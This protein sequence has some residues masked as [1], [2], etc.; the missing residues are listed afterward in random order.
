MTKYGSRGGH[1]FQCPG[2]K[3]II[4]ETSEDRKVKDAMIK[5]L[6]LNGD[7]VVDCTPGNCGENADLKYGTDKANANKVD[8]FLP[9]HFNSAANNTSIMGCE[10][11]LNPDNKS[12]VAMGNRIL[13]KLSGLGFKNR[14][15]KD[16]VNEEH[17]HDIKQSDMPAVLIEVCFVGASGD[18]ALYKKLGPDIIGKAIAEGVVGHSIGAKVTTQVAEK[19]SPFRIRLGWDNEKSQI[20]AFGQYQQA[21]D[22]A[23][24]H[25]GYYVY[26]N[27]GKNLYTLFVEKPTVSKKEPFRVVA[28]SFDKE[29]GANKQME[30]LKKLGI[31]SF[32]TQK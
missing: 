1:N 2:A 15:Y 17:L 32:K 22:F 21:K 20:G 24:L 14:G 18:V 26:D 29:S 31:A 16:G 10:V 19:N 13:S 8:F 30:D 7:T 3:G 25:V 23:N 9:V 27:N 28:G 12:A 5:Y 11:W 6:K 4:E